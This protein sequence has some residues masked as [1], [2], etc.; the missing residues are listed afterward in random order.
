[1]KDTYKRMS[2]VNQLEICDS[3]NSSK[4]PSVQ[5]RNATENCMGETEIC[6]P[7]ETDFY[8]QF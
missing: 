6:I 8:L 1:M 5:F 3:L 4:F 2:L 7:V